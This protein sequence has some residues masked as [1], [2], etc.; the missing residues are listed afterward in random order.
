MY[1]FT[2]LDG[3]QIDE[4]TNNILNDKILFQYHEL[5]NTCI[6]GIEILFEP[7][8]KQ[9]CSKCDAKFW[10]SQYTIQ[11]KDCGCCVGCGSKHG[12]D[13]YFE[14][15]YVC[16]KEFG[17]FDNITKKCI[18]P[19]HIRSSTCLEYTCYE[20]YEIY[21][22]RDVMTLVHAIKCIRD[23][24]IREESVKNA[25]RVLNRVFEEL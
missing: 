18:L 14:T 1:Q 6:H 9:Y 23:G 7:F 11:K 8:N 22:K 15:V 25:I 24:F 2:Q 5:Y 20:H 13:P 17:Y 19:R 12:Y 3:T 16:D 4:V 10:I 21:F